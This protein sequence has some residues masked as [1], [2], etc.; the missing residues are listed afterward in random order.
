[1]LS[2]LQQEA[3]ELES[4]CPKHELTSAAPVRQPWPKS[5]ISEALTAAEFALAR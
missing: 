5:L 4:C 2:L 3:E 1:M